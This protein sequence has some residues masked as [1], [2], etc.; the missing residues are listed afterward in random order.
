MVSQNLAQN[1]FITSQTLVTKEHMV[2]D[3]IL[4]KQLYSLVLFSVITVLN[5]QQPEAV[6]Q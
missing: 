6:Y 4:F 5:Y 1:N 3:I 2:I